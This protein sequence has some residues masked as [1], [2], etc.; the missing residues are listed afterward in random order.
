ML[1]LPALVFTLLFLISK[2]SFAGP[3][4]ERLLKKEKE[5]ATCGKAMEKET[6]DYL[7]QKLGPMNR[8]GRAEDC[9]WLVTKNRIV[10][11]KPYLKYNHCYLR[12]QNPA[13]FCK[14]VFED[15][16]FK[17][18]DDLDLPCYRGP[19]DPKAPSHFTC[20]QNRC[21][22][23]YD[24]KPREWYRENYRLYQM[25]SKEDPTCKRELAAFYEKMTKKYLPAKRGQR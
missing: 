11:E 14:G 4:Y 5:Y 23:H 21:V 6:A 18:T 8:C 16:P 15:E 2:N 25:N 1:K 13:A 19:V 24:G 20:E 12:I 9:I 17:C 3:L 10:G 7:A 22:P